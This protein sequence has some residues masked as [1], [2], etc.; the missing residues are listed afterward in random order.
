MQ[1]C[2]MKGDVTDDDKVET[3]TSFSGV[4]LFTSTR[5]GAADLEVFSHHWENPLVRPGN[6]SLLLQL[7]PPQSWL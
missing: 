2:N 5:M 6:C 1:T 7:Q 3:M 4:S